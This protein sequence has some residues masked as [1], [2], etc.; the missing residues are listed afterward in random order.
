MKESEYLRLKKKITDEYHEK[1][2]ALEMVW[3]MSSESS[4]KNSEGTGEEMGA[5]ARGALTLLV[6]DTVNVVTG[7][8]SSAY[9]ENAL[10]RQNPQLRGKVRRASISQILRRLAE[11]GMIELVSEGK[12]RTPAIYQKL[13]QVKKE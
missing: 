13:K 9:I 12:G 6:R 3:T 11:E 8:V 5:S 4:V 10:V 7:K 1:M 2:R